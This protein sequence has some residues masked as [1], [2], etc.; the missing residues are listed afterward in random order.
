MYM[1]YLLQEN[2]EP[3]V[4][5]AIQLT[6]PPFATAYVRYVILPAIVYAIKHCRTAVYA[7]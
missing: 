5:V 3:C 7:W 1:S 2:V 4:S 6:G